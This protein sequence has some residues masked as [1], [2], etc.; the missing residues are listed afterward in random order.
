MGYPARLALTVRQIRLV[1][2]S[3]TSFRFADAT[4]VFVRPMRVAAEVRRRTWNIRVPMRSAN[5]Q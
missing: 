3:A 2:S 4:V 1:T 5:P